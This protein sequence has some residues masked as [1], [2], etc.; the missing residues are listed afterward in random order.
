M[1]LHYFVGGENRNRMYH[2]R[3]AC[4]SLSQV[5][6]ILCRQMFD[7]CAY[8]MFVVGLKHKWFGFIVLG[9]R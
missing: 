7:V 2:C 1:N 6:R 3:D 4:I 9:T 8:N 5:C